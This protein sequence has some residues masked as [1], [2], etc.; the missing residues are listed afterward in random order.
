MMQL[1]LN[2]QKNL[3]IKS[4]QIE[5]N[6]NYINQFEAVKKIMSQNDFKFKYKKRNEN[7]EAYKNKKFLKLYNY[8]YER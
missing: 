1:D 4:L 7:L 2:L 6:E 8:Y 3:K 5:L